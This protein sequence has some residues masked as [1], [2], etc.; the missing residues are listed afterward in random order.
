M[1]HP[2]S[3]YQDQIHVPLVI[4]YPKQT[5][6]S[7]VAEV[8][9]GADLMPTIVEAAGIPA[10]PVEGVSLLHPSKERFV[11]AERFPCGEDNKDKRLGIKKSAVMQGK[12][13]LI[14]NADGSRDDS[15]TEMLP[16][17]AVADSMLAALD[18]RKLSPRSSGKPVQVSPETLERL[19]SLGYAR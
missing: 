12:W 1:E 18:A 2:V 4:K 16:D 11:F 10:V 19:K 8:A 15:E 9:S 14:V 6:A 5:A 3:L 7:S 17:K 13:K